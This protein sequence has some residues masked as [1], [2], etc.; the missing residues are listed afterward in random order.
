[1]T[2]LIRLNK[3]LSESG[4]CSRREAD[5]HILSGKVK[6]NDK[7]ASLGDKV[8]PEKDH[9][10]FY[11]KLIKPHKNNLVYYAVYKP[12]GIISTSSDELNR[13][14][15]VS[16][17]PEKPRVYPV[18]R[19]DKDSEGLIILTN[20]GDLTLELSHPSREHEKEYAVKI[21]ISKPQ[22]IEQSELKRL[23]KEL[24][25]GL[26]IDGT[27]M[28]MKNTSIKALYNK[29]YL[30]NT[31]LTTGYNRQIRKMCA[32]LGLGVIELKRIRIGKLKLDGLKLQP[33]KYKRILKEDII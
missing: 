19:L 27:I 5:Q 22:V 6:I 7:I 18:G 25:K 23:E 33:G 10:Y 14:N 28:K 4:V 12:K 9:V 26:E 2:N 16:L 15:V 17:V 11:D 1:M 3:F 8:D 32:K 20:D 30:L 29:Y 31:T 13:E 21:T 24:R